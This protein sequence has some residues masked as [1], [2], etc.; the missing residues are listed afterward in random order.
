M[1]QEADLVARRLSRL[2]TYL[3]R[4]TQS[5]NGP[6]ELNELYEPDSER[7]AFEE[8]KKDSGD[9]TD[10][11]NPENKHPF[12]EGRLDYG[13]PPLKLFLHEGYYVRPCSFGNL[14]EKTY[15]GICAIISEFFS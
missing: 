5:P 1:Y 9:H 7:L 2:I 15:E 10:L 13:Q 3:L 6:Y 4:R 11:A 14:V 12:D 8:G